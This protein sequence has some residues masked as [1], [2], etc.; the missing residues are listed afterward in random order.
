MRAGILLNFS[1]VSSAFF[2]A[3]FSISF[4]LTS[5]ILEIKR[6]WV[7]SRTGNSTPFSVKA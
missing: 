2:S 5:S 7:M 3:F 4:N 6:G 1:A